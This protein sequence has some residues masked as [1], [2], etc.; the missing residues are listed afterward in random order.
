MPASYLQCRSFYQPNL[1][2]LFFILAPL[3]LQVVVGGALYSLFG[4]SAAAP[5]AA[6]LASLVNA[7]RLL[8]GQRSIGFINPTLYAAANSVREF[9]DDR[10]SLAR[11]YPT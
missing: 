4:T 5:V 6:A 2:D 9:P 10:I 11:N 3:S 8:A 1:P 7:K